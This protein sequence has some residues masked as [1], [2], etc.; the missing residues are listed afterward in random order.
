MVGKLIID[1]DL[2]GIQIRAVLADG[3]RKSVPFDKLRT[4]LSQFDVVS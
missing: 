4:S 2:G 3:E 1:V